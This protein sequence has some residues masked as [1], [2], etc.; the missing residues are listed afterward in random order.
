MIPTWN[1]YA[2]T[3]H[4]LTRRNFIFLNYP[5]GFWRSLEERSLN[6]ILNSHCI[7][8]ARHIKDM[9]L[10]A[11]LA[12]ASAARNSQFIKPMT[13]NTPSGD[14]ETRNFSQDDFI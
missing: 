6:F 9:A 7:S 5:R 13:L 3:Q 14:Y 12:L 1:L 11:S 10:L 4:L 8:L 2:V